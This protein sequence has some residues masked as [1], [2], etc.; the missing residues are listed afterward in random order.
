MKISVK[1]ITNSSQDKVEQ[2]CENE[3]KVYV[4]AK[5]VKGEANKKVREALCEYFSLP[6]HKVALVG[7]K[8]SKN[9]LFKIE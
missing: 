2:T 6:K 5:P 3:Y 1:V 7:G 8:T 4:H 9:K